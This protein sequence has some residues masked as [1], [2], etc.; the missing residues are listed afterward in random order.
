MA[1]ELLVET[2]TCIC[3][4]STHSAV[5]A[6]PTPYAWRRTRRPRPDRHPRNSSRPVARRARRRHLERRPGD[7]GVEPHVGVSS[8]SVITTRWFGFSATREMTCAPTLERSISVPDL[9]STPATFSA[10]L[11]RGARRVP[12]WSS[13]CATEARRAAPRGVVTV[14]RHD[15]DLGL[16]ESRVGLDAVDQR[17]AARRDGEQALERDHLGTAL[18]DGLQREQR[19]GIGECQHVAVD[20]AGATPRRMKS[21]W[22]LARKVAGP[23]RN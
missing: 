15:P 2:E 6:I 23:A 4:T 1:R 16:A 9:P 8:V 7:R 22:P 11:K 17:R 21:R 13:A 19:V 18:H 20:R 12:R 5:R 10:I 3:A 14:V